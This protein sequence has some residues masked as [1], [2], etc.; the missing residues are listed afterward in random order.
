M[1][2]TQE[3]IDKIAAKDDSG[4]G[5]INEKVSSDDSGAEEEVSEEDPGAELEM[6]DEEQDGGDE[7]DER[8]RRL[9][10]R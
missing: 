7:F 10:G 9:L 4:G 5:E 3:A 6:I 8:L 1:S 2:I